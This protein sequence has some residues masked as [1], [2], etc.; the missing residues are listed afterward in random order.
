M[1]VIRSQIVQQNTNRNLGERCVSGHC[2]PCSFPVVLKYF[3]VKS[4]GGGDSVNSIHVSVSSSPK[5]RISDNNPSDQFSYVRICQIFTT[6]AVIPGIFI[7]HVPPPSIVLHLLSQI[8]CTP[9]EVCVSKYHNHNGLLKNGSPYARHCFMC[10]TR[11]SAFHPPSHWKGR[12]YSWRQSKG[13]KQ[14]IKKLIP[15]GDCK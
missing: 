5:T 7:F 13:T 14:V 6:T 1:S 8:V 2:Y 15:L 11:M 9:K 4:W 3:Q 10:F 12:Y